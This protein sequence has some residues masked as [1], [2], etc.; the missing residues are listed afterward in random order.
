MTR[1][2]VRTV[3]AVFLSTVAGATLAQQTIASL[4][5]DTSG[6][7][8][9]ARLV[10]WAQQIDARWD[11]ITPPDA[12]GIMTITNLHVPFGE[13]VS[14]LPPLVIMIP[15]VAVSD[16][17]D[18]FSGKIDRFRMGFVPLIDIECELVGGFVEL[19][20]SDGSLQ[21]RALEYV[22]V[23]SGELLD[24]LFEWVELRFGQDMQG[25][26][27]DSV[28]LEIAGRGLVIDLGMDQA[29]GAKRLAASL[30]ESV[31]TMR[32]DIPV[33]GVTL[34]FEFTVTTE[35][36]QQTVL[37]SSTG[38]ISSVAEAA[39]TSTV[40]NMVVGFVESTSRNT[41]TRL[42]ISDDTIDFITARK[43]GWMIQ[44]TVEGI[45]G[46]THGDYVFSVS[47]DAYKGVDLRMLQED[48]RSTSDAS[49]VPENGDDMD[50]SS[51]DPMEIHMDLA[52]VPA[53]TLG[54]ALLR[55]LP[56]RL[57][58]SPERTLVQM[59]STPWTL[60]LREFRLAGW[61]ADLDATAYLNFD[62]FQTPNVRGTAAIS[63]SGLPVFLS[64]L[65]IYF[66]G[67][68][69]IVP[70]HQEQFVVDMLRSTA[71]R[72]SS[73]FDLNYSFETDAEGMWLLNGQPF[74]QVFSRAMM[75]AR[76]RQQ[77]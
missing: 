29:P 22:D 46:S 60:D 10:S 28:A 75:S 69:Q 11:S 25:F 76:L 57:I 24:S 59:I 31:G 5:I 1:I 37:R 36:L 74:D 47:V 38:V 20:D 44:K 33:G 19:G 40:M 16:T 53:E 58:D 62:V 9:D 14:D 17:G 7:P 43:D 23:S 54:G 18:G 45:I 51:V 30:S 49:R 4:S 71:A 73:F 72:G 70:L 21:I 77:R 34:P 35:G 15:E 61:G 12:D 64:K 48:F 65:K 66:D 26:D 67:Y 42:K 6:G 2:I 63:L 39:K 41:V 52:M 27:T 13:F 55:R 68:K 50:L 56:Q 8:T 32:F 3:F